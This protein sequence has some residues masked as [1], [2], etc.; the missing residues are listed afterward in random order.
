M[1]Y[2]RSATISGAE[3]E[4]VRNF[5]LAVSGLIAK[6]RDAEERVEKLLRLLSSP[7]TGAGP[8]PVVP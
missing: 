6:S 5:R 1:Y 4:A 7:A 3:S 2:L 8:A